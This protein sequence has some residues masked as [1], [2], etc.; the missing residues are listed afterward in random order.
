MTGWS[1]PDPTK[2]V[3]SIHRPWSLSR[4]RVAGEQRKNQTSYPDLA[5][6]FKQNGLSIQRSFRQFA[7]GFN[8]PKWT[9]LPPGSTTNCYS[10]CHQFQ[11]P[12]PGQ[13]MHSVCPGKIWAGMPSHQS[14]SWAKWWRSCRTTRTTE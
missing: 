1:E 5:R 6:P 2:L 11:T 13:F 4:T 3:S 10:L 7:L 9:C 8:S 12:R 14:P